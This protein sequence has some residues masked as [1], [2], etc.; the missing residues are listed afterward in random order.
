MS[1]RTS[2]RADCWRDRQ[3]QVLQPQ[4]R[5]SHPGG[6]LS[7]HG[8]FPPTA[9]GRLVPAMCL[10]PSRPTADY[11]LLSQGQQSCRPGARA[12]PLSMLG[13]RTHTHRTWHVTEVSYVCLGTHGP[14]NLWL[15]FQRQG[16]RDTSAIR[17][18]TR[19][20]CGHGWRQ[21]ELP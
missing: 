2:L 8:P 7:K 18:T 9:P 12:I 15:V 17:K 14:L 21:A 6:G 13:A 20:E 3:G 16:Y 1:H 4:G 11:Q 5:R 19:S 10:P